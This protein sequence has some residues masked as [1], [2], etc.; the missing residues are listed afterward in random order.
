MK[1]CYLCGKRTDDCL[2]DPPVC[3]TCRA[4]EELSPL[5]RGLDL[6][7]EVDDTLPAGVVV[8]KNKDGREV[9]R[10]VNV[11]TEDAATQTARNLAVAREWAVGWRAQRAA[12]K[13]AAEKR[14]DTPPS[15]PAPARVEIVD[16]VPASPSAPDEARHSMYLLLS[17]LPVA[18]RPEIL[19]E[20]LAAGL[21]DAELAASLTRPEGE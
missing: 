9:A 12:E 15:A 1:P 11:G 13:L 10:V 6:D 19:G 20:L 4:R 17:E 18:D 2:F 5:A 8:L 21:I 7:V 16:G 3:K 14:R